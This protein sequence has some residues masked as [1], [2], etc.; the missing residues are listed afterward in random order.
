V[1]IERPVTEPAARITVNGHEAG[2]F[3]GRPYRLDITR[4]LKS[5][6]NT[7]KIGL[8]APTAARLLVVPRTNLKS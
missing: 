3:I 1:E 7:L 5:G 8:F 4:H 6:Q 2:G